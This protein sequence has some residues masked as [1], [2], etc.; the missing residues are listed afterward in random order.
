MVEICIL[1][2]DGKDL[3]KANV[4]LEEDS[5]TV[6]VL[7]GWTIIF[8]GALGKMIGNMNGWGKVRLK[9]PLTEIKLLAISKNWADRHLFE[10]TLTDG[11][12]CTLAFN[13]ENDLTAALK[14]ALSDRILGKH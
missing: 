7:P 9:T 1:T 14:D 2:L 10:L 11:R 12:V 3:G 4:T 13:A 8:F 5:L 6:R